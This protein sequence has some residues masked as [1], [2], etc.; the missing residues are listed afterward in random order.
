MADD[1]QQAAAVGPSVPCEVTM[2]RSKTAGA[3]RAG[4]AAAPTFRGCEAAK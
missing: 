1:D 4:R 3:R 2:I